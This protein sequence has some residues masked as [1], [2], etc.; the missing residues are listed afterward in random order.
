M[1]RM[2]LCTIFLLWLI[3]AVHC[4]SYLVEVDDGNSNSTN[5]AEVEKEGADFR[6]PYCQ[7]CP[8]ANCTFRCCMKCY[9]RNSYAKKMKCRKLRRC[10]GTNGQPPPI[11][12]FW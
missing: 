2:I 9:N 3:N 11:N 8:N 5:N 7:R 6:V 10:P 1:K 4:K 12:K